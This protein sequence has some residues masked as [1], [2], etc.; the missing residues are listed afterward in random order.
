MGT[1]HIIFIYAI[2]SILLLVFFYFGIPWIYGRWNRMQL[3]HKT[4]ALKA[5]VLTLDDGP[6]DKLTTDIL[7]LLDEYN[8]KATLFLLG[9]NI[10]G[11]KNIV[12][13]IAK[14]GH[15]ICSH[16]YS[17]INH[18]TVMPLRALK[19]INQGWAAIDKALSNNR[20]AYPFRPPFGKLNIISLLYLL[21]SRVPVFYW[22]LDLG[23]T[24]KQEPGDFNQRTVLAINEGGA[25]TLIHDFDRNSNTMDIFV[26]GSLRSLLKASSQNNFK[27]I[28]MS[29]LLN[30]KN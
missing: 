30:R 29:T 23:D 2:I 26:L 1:N 6:G 5:I 14:R 24:W 3:S 12:N 27:L 18:W 20:G 15:E 11:R 4:K 21:F 25:V 8:A 9:R 28:T 13:N 22:T 10:E 19:D 7:D 16:G 17:H